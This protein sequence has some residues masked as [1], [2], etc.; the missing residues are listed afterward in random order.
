MSREDRCSFTKK[1]L[2]TKEI[3]VYLYQY[4]LIL[5]HT[6]I[7]VNAWIRRALPDVERDNGRGKDDTILVTVLSRHCVA[8][9]TH[10]HIKNEG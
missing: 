10:I 2:F 8:R 4:I 9:S 3:V 1:N 5:S 7:S 6:H